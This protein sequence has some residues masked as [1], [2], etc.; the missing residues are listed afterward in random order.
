MMS[1]QMIRDLLVASQ[2]TENELSQRVFTPCLQKM[3]M[4]MSYA[5]RDVRFVGGSSEQG[6]DIE[7]YEVIGPDK[8]RIYTGVQLKKS[9]VNQAD[10][11][12]LIRQGT[13]AFEKSVTDPSSGTSYRIGRW[14]LG[15]TG[16]IT[17]P[18]RERI[19]QEL[20]RYGKLISFWD[21]IRLSEFILDHYYDEFVRELGVNP[22]LA[23][24][25]NVRVNL[26]D[27]ESPFMLAQKFDAVDWMQM[28]LS[29]A[30]PSVGTDGVFLVFY[31][32]DSNLP[33]VRVAVR[34]SKDDIVVDSVMSQVNLILVKL[35][36]GETSCKIRLFDARRPIRVACRGFRF[37]L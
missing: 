37:V 2:L 23:G 1:P 6:N 21:G 7:F 35:A 26:W 27:P 8:H 16:N 12:D 11:T 14:V 25:Q 28:D 30:V 15:A 32:L 29:S 17:S 13:Q 3:S 9:D 31:P 20:S 34:T 19:H 5:L 18:A 36:P 33:T 10:A 24:S 4:V 22:V